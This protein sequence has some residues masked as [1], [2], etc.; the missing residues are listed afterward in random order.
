M[1]SELNEKVCGCLGGV[2]LRVKGSDNDQKGGWRM[3]S[4]HPVTGPGH[5]S[6]VLMERAATPVMH[7][8]QLLPLLCSTPYPFP[9]SVPP[10]FHLESALLVHYR[11][12]AV[13]L[14]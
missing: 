12:T 7:P 2:G 3:A 1:C 11:V 14:L 4:D 9:S 6:G 10:I 13:F 8:L 5:T